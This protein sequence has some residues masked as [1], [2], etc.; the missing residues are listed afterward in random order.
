[1]LCSLGRSSSKS[2]QL[3]YLRSPSLHLA[4]STYLLLLPLQ[5]GAGSGGGRDFTPLRVLEREY[6]LFQALRRLPV[7]INCV[8]SVAFQVW[9]QTA[10]RRR[11]AAAGAALASLLPALN[12]P[13]R[14]ALIGLR[15]L[16]D[17]T[18]RLRLLQPRGG[19]SAGGDEGEDSCTAADVGGG[20]DG[21]AAQAAASPW[22]DLAHFV[23]AQHRQRACAAAALAATAA[24]A[25]RLVRGACDESLAAHF[26]RMGLGDSSA[27]AGAAMSL[28]ADAARD[29]ALEQSLGRDMTFAQRGAIQRACRHLARF[30]RL[31]DLMLASATIDAA[32]ATAEALCDA[33]CGGSGSCGGASGGAGGAANQSAID[34]PLLVARFDVV[35]SSAEPDDDAATGNNIVVSGGGGVCWRLSPSADSVRAALHTALGDA[36]AVLSAA[37]TRLASHAAMARIMLAA[38]DDVEE[39]SGSLTRAPASSLV[40]ACAESKSCANDA[41][42]AVASHPRYLAVLSSLNACVAAAYAAVACD[43]TARLQPHAKRCAAVNAAA[44][45]VAAS[46]SNASETIDAVEGAAAAEAEVD[47]PERSDAVWIGDEVAA[48]AAAVAAVDAEAATTDDAAAAA[49][50]TLAPSPVPGAE[51]DDDAEGATAAQAGAHVVQLALASAAASGADNEECSAG[52]RGGARSDADDAA[53]ASLAAAQDLMEDAAS[54]FACM[55]VAG[56]A[57]PL[58]RVDATRPRAAC[59]AATARGLELL[60]VAMPRRLR[61]AT[62][63]LAAEARARERTLL[64]LAGASVDDGFARDSGA[65][66]V[67]PAL[68]VVGRPS[69]DHARACAAHARALNRARVAM[70]LLLARA[71][72]CA[73]LAERGKGACWPHGERLSALRHVAARDLCALH[74]VLQ[75]GEARLGDSAAAAAAAD[76][77][78]AVGSLSTATA[79]LA[80]RHAPPVSA[81]LVARRAQPAGC[82]ADTG[83]EEVGVAESDVEQAALGTS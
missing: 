40:A 58:L 8:R 82:G 68:P 55:P 48:A 5:F 69:L 52:E 43:W 24:D 56:D 49:P 70:P 15:A 61:A 6:S 44:A 75:R 67:A 80:E 30:I 66:F 81:E 73:A 42:E 19:A 76:D 28:D 79:A 36:L 77:I 17:A 65:P 1:M 10:R 25:R 50:A 47:E 45:A 32:L 35:R 3:S 33:V 63:A 57:L 4:L 11:T 31:C 7:I 46:A 37:P 83:E 26:A 59:L 18:A 71:A 64:A 53:L 29:A 27:A 21:G 12:T 13:Q 23:A 41:I 2:S 62:V 78:V 14:R 60:R 54:A 16:C 9:R 34:V 20:G 39:A 74:A 72:R 38:S 22:R 51:A